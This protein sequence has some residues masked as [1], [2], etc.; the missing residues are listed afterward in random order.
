MSV[1]A[2]VLEEFAGQLPSDPEEQRQVL[3]LGLRELRIHKALD[4]FRR[5]EGSLAFAARSADVPLRQMIPL[6]YAYGLE[7][8]TDHDLLDADELSLE[9]ASEL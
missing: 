2:A 3:I 4:A 1:T 9:Q 7:P 6:A 8:A 5:G